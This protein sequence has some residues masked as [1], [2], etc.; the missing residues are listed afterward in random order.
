MEPYSPSKGA[1]SKNDLTPEPASL[2]IRFKTRGGTIGNHKTK[3]S[4]GATPGQ[5]GKSWRINRHLH[6]Q[7]RTLYEQAMA[8]FIQ[9]RHQRRPGSKEQQNVPA[10]EEGRRK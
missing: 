4:T 1:T 8:L 3:H 6:S 2:S 7:K 9:D 5:I 10:S